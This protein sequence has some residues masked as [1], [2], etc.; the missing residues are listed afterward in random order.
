LKSA[1]IFKIWKKKLDTGWAG[2]GQQAGEHQK[3]ILK[4]RCWRSPT[5]LHVR[6][7]RETSGAP[8]AP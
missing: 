8:A 5:T 3:R 6:G 7:T 1:Y 2:G 4:K